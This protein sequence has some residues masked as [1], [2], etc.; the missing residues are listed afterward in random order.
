M[1]SYVTMVIFL[2]FVVLSE[3]MEMVETLLIDIT[4]STE[5]GNGSGGRVSERR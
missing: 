1:C 4:A 5:A 3:Q 2:L